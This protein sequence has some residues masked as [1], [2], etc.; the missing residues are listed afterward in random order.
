MTLL[1]LIAALMLAPPS[2]NMLKNPGFNEGLAG[3]V[4]EGAVST[5]GAASIRLGP[6]KA[7]VRQRY[8]VPGLRI[9]Y[10][11]A[12]MTGKGALL[13]LQCFNS[14]NR[15][16][17]EATA[18]PDAKHLAGIYTK[19][20]AFT[21]YVVVSLENADPG[22]TVEAGDAVLNDDDRDRVEHP[23]TI[24][25]AAL[26][27]PIWTG[28]RVL[29]E[30]VLL[31][32]RDGGPF[33]GKLMFRPTRVLA[34][35]SP[36]RGREYVQGRDFVVRGD[37]IEALP[38]SD[39][40]T[41]R[42]SEFA[43]GQFPWTDLSGRHV[44]VTYEHSDT[45]TGP[46]PER[47]GNLLPRTLGLL[48]RRAPVT[49]AALGD[50]ITLGMFCSGFRNVPPYQPP[51]VNLFADAL[52][53][54]YH[55]PKIKVYNAAVGGTTSDWGLQVAPD[56]IGAL[57]PDLVIVAFGMNDFW[58]NS[59]AVFRKNIE[60]IMAEVRSQAPH[61]EFVLVSSIEFNADYTNDPTY[62]ANLKGYAPELAALKGP[63]V[64]FLDMT[65]M[66]DAL[67]KAKSPEDLQTD[68]MHPDDFFARWYAQGLIETL[69]TQ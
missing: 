36:E 45:W 7:A 33:S 18:Q 58:S 23:C 54:S 52:G 21:K 5:A 34:V 29:N 63:G 26:M 31:L 24:D 3:W 15:Q 51:W 66:S 12:R 39:I 40:P 11:A 27:R 64:G 30:S 9:L 4:S 28:G 17:F 13:R 37:R 1:V 32:S 46:L 43:T 10:V 16:V 35:S 49:I 42:A 47:Q 41:M 56:C 48:R 65:R 67:Y 68:P 61:A 6:G 50:S 44:F 60:G 59:P 8:A 2:Q 22:G 53:R 55:D 57:K 20:Q 14:G 19:T 38:G 62:V 69:K 25:Q